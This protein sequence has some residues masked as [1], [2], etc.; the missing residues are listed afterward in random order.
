MGRQA[1]KPQRAGYGTLARQRP[2]IR[3]IARPAPPR[4]DVCNPAWLLLELPTALL[5]AVF[6]GTGWLGYIQT[7]GTPAQ[8][9]PAVVVP[10]EEHPEGR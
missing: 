3:R 2:P 4:D 1:R 8:P 9:R 6:V 7:S 5:L 10:V